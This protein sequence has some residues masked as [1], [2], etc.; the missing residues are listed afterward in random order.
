MQSRFTLMLAQQLSPV[1]PSAP[2]PVALPDSPRS[3]TPAPQAPEA[4]APSPRIQELTAELQ[5]AWETAHA[6][7]QAKGEFL[8]MMSHELRTPLT[9]VIG[10]SATLLRW[11]FG[12]LN[13]RQREYLQSIYDSGEHLLQLIESILDFSQAESGQARLNVRHFSVRRLA[14]YCVQLFQEAAEQAGIT[15]KT[16]ISLTPEEDD[17]VVDPQRIRQILINLL[18]N[19]IKF[20][21][22]GGEVT[23][24]VDAQRGGILFQIIDTGIGIDP[25]QQ[26][27]L[28][29][30]F[31]QLEDSHRR[32]YQGSGLGL[33]LAKH[34]VDLHRAPS[35]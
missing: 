20:T 15:L 27:L 14:N 7:E 17:F 12:P 30:Q 4:I 34:Q 19:A 1:P 23:L 22:E 5:K 33:A 26:P 2:S 13:D 8:A 11:S 6:A 31:Q 16:V 21:N 9:C 18:D 24:Q 28:F 10:M 25:R 32:R 3:A 35:S 29:Q